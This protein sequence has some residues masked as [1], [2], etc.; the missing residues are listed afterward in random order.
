[1]VMVVMMMMATTSA[2]SNLPD[3]LC[4]V[5]SSSGIGEN[6]GGEREG[7]ADVSQ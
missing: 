1:M 4:Q 6:K 2:T 5:N 3:E 7:H